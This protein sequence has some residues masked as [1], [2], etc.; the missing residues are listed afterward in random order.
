MVYWRKEL[1]QGDESMKFCPYCGKELSTQS[2]FCPYC[3]KGLFSDAP[4]PIIETQ[5]VNTHTKTVTTDVPN[6]KG[7]KKRL[8]PLIVLFIVIGLAAAL[9][10]SSRS[11]NFTEDPDAIQKAASSV[12]KLYM[13]DYNGILRSTGSGFAA[14]DK[15]IIITNHHCIE[16]DVYSI[17]AQ[18]EDG[19]IFMIDSVIAYDE[20]KDLAVLRAPDC[21]LTPLKTAEGLRMKKGEKVA[22]IGSPKGIASMFSTGIISNILDWGTH[23]VLSSTASISHGSSGGALFNNRGKVIAITSAGH[24]DGNEIYYNV[25]IE[26]A[27]E[28][29]DTRSPNAEMTITEFYE[30]SEHPYNV[31]YLLAFGSK[32]DGK[33]VIAYGYVSGFDSLIYLVSSP[34]Q[35]LN[36]NNQTSWTLQGSL[37]LDSQPALKVQA[38]EST[39]LI[40]SVYTGDLVAVEGVV[41]YYDSTD[42]RIISSTIEKIE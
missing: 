37:L 40:N 22:A 10:L 31:D 14:F 6:A 7:S 30:Q 4:A 39:T 33:T 42:V 38:D 17:E 3:G 24:V 23:Y 11:G 26:Y 15:D 8:L 12:V 20:E 34:D 16:G 2:S 13:Y 1:T 41:R 19:S 32:L 25:P 36:I 9:I 28:L 18:R 5:T 29:Y 35:A 21:G 27:K